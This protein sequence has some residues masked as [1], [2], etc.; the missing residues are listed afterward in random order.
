MNIKKLLL[1]LLLML[2]LSVTLA[3]CDFSGINSNTPGG[4]EGGTETPETPEAPENPEQPENPEAPEQSE[5]PSE[6]KTLAYEEY[7]DMTAEEQE[8][9]IYS[10]E[11]IRDFFL[12]HTEAKAKYD[13][14]HK[15]PEIGGDVNIGDLLGPQE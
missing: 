10:F 15:V 7:L 13:E 1:T 8:A 2:L 9:F 12:W 14:E 4:G 3:S 6:E 11:D 5:T